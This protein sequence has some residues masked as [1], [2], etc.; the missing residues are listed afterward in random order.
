[1]QIGGRGSRMTLR[2]DRSSRRLGYGKCRYRE[3]RA[4]PWQ[5]AESRLGA[6][7]GLS[8]LF[9][10]RSS[11]ALLE[12][13]SVWEPRPTKLCATSTYTRRRRPGCCQ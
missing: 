10:R 6:R 13:K 4:E 11:P 7:L 1:M 9:C 5:S 3:E 8:A 2:F 12:P